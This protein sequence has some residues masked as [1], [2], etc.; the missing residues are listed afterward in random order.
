MKR[1]TI[2]NRF[3]FRISVLFKERSGWL[4]KSQI[5]TAQVVSPDHL[6]QFFAID[7]PPDQLWLPWMV[8]FAASGPP[9]NIIKYGST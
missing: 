9:I 1:C 2:R 5:V 4:S 6:W 8:R 7:G 3:G